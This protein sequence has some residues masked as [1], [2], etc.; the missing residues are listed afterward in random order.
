MR[1]QEAF[2]PKPYLLVSEQKLQLGNAENVPTARLHANIRAEKAAL[3]C[4]S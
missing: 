3:V 2:G 1:L 4:C